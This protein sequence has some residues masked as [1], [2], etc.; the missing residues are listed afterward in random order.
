MR[1]CMKASIIYLA[2]M[3][4]GK[5]AVQGGVGNTHMSPRKAFS[6][7]LEAFSAVHLFLVQFRKASSV[8]HEPVMHASLE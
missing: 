1:V 4:P 5:R 3:M 6:H 7:S 2:C 8:C